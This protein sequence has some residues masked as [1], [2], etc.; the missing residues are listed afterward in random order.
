PASELGGGTRRPRAAKTVQP[1]S[2]EPYTQLALL[3]SE[4]GDPGR[5][6]TYLRGARARDPDDWRLWLSEA[7]LLNRTGDGPAAR[8]AYTRAESLSPVPLESVLA[9]QG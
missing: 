1:W 7:S 5:A 4:R 8:D 6:L 9:Q 2:S 3:E